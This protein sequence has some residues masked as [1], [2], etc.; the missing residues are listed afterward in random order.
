M[1]L[2]C[3]FLLFSFDLI[4]L[5]YQSPR[6]GFASFLCGVLLLQLPSIQMKWSFGHIY[7]YCLCLSLHMFRKFGL[8]AGLNQTKR[9]LDV[10][11]PNH[12]LPMLNAVHEVAIYIHRFHNLDLFEQGS[13]LINFYSMNS[14]TFFV[15]LFLLMFH[16]YS[17]LADGTGS[18]LPWDGRTVI[19]MILIP[20][21][22]LELFSMKV[23]YIHTNVVSCFRVYVSL[24]NPISID[25]DM[26]SKCLLFRTWNCCTL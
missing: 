5:L 2:L 13:A 1:L 24:F 12:H 11:Q 9:L 26:F 8:F 20:G 14:F 25:W 3:L 22:L 4:P 15:I 19:L 18:R 7:H 16:S 21:F 6:W 17:C 10:Q 23:K